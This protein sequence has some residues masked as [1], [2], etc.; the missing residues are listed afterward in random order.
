M[1]AL[2]LSAAAQHMIHA[3]LNVY[4][5]SEKS[6]TSWG[7]SYRWEGWKAVLKEAETV[8][9]VKARNDALS[10]VVAMDAAERLHKM[11]GEEANDYA[12]NVETVG[13]KWGS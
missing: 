4:T 2:A 13:T 5:Y 6:R 10:A 8:K 9:N 7:L 12:W 3:A 1:S 11:K